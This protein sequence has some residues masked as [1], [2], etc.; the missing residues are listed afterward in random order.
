M[1]NSETDLRMEVGVNMQTH[2]LPSHLSHFNHFLCLYSMVAMVT[3]ENSSKNTKN[4]T[5]MDFSCD[6]CLI[7]NSVLA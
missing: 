7:N 6:K 1:P 5:K 2:R 3:K 4:G